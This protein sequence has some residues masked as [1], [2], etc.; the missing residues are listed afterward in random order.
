MNPLWKWNNF[1]TNYKIFF[2]SRFIDYNTYNLELK[3]YGASTVSS[4]SWFRLRAMVRVGR[5][6]PKLKTKLANLP[7]EKAVIRYEMKKKVRKLGVNTDK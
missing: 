3:M 7:S 4:S 2:F 5:L 1:I 6:N